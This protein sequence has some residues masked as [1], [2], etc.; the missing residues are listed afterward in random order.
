MQRPEKESLTGSVQRQETA[1]AVRRNSR[2][3]NASSLHMRGN[4]ASET[5]YAIEE[6]LQAELPDSPPAAGSTS[7]RQGR[8]NQ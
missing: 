4:D 7:S 3:R 6:V 1:S 8:S 5:E 2:R